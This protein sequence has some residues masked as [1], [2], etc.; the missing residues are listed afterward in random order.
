MF[1][2]IL[3]EIQNINFITQAKRQQSKMVYVC[4]FP[5]SRYSPL[6]HPLTVDMNYPLPTRSLGRDVQF[7]ISK[8]KFSLKKSLNLMVPFR[9][10]I[11]AT[12]SIRS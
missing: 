7:L 6:L 2:V 8:W 12:G 1:L 9:D 11:L 5:T 3:S 10:E 4:G